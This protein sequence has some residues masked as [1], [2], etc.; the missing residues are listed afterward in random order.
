MYT[1]LERAAIRTMR[2]NL[3]TWVACASTHERHLA[4]TWY[5]VA[6][7]HAQGLASTY[8][9]SIHQAC[10]VLSVLSPGCDWD[11]NIRN[12]EDVCKAWVLESYDAVV[13]TYNGQL[14][15]AYHILDSGATLTGEGMFPFISQH[16]AQKTRAF[17]LN[18]LYPQ[19]DTYVT[20]D[21]WILRALGLDVQRTTPKLYALGTRAMRIMAK[22]YGVLPQQMQALVWV[23]IRTRDGV[24]QMAMP[25]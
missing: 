2:T 21:R 16:S 20:I 11:T 1:E 6:H 5:D 19:L 15:K 25:F 4:L 8:G 12:A 7:T 13:S 3:E 17:Y 18:I 23:C 22:H 9:I 10:A 24:P 14:Q